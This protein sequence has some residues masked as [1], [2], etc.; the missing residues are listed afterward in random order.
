MKRSGYRV[1]PAHREFEP[2]H[3]HECEDMTRY[4]VYG[5]SQELDGCII[6]YIISEMV[7]PGY[8]GDATI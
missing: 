1:D 6:E 4:V 3:A 8:F 7:G 5:R 2:W